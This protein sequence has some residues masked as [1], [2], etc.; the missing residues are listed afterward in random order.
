MHASMTTGKYLCTCKLSR[1]IKL[2]WTM[3][4]EI[5]M[6]CDAMR[7]DVMCACVFVWLACEHVCACVCKHTRMY[8]CA[9]VFV[10]VRRFN[11]SQNL[12]HWALN[13]PK[14]YCVLH[15]EIFQNKHTITN[16]ARNKFHF[17]LNSN[18]L[19]TRTKQIRDNLFFLSCSVF[20][21]LFAMKKSVYFS[22]TTN[23]HFIILFY[24]AYKLL[25]YVLLTFFFWQYRQ[26]GSLI[27]IWFCD[28]SF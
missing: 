25:E 4:K 17:S 18:F 20:S 14:I 16:I 2:N 21:F 15:K 5:E 13:R 3:T 6:W 26:T 8:V 7:F 28:R 10:Y 19:S 9:N 22:H 27:H 11:L 24:L 12:N 23:L 1:Q